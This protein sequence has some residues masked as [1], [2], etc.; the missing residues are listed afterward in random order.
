[1][2]SRTVFILAVAMTPSAALAQ[3]IDLT[4]TGR[5][6]RAPKSGPTGPVDVRVDL[7]NKSVALPWGNFP[8]TKADRQAVHFRR[9][10]GA[11]VAAG[12]LDRVAGTLRMSWKKPREVAREREGKQAVTSRFA[13]LWCAV[14]KLF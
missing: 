11:F 2:I 7:D 8:I 4:C 3:V 14:R 1:M 5:T 10:D 13:W 9:K 6:Y 12:I